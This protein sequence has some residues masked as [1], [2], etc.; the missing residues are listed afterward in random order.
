MGF[1]VFGLIVFLTL[2][3][4]ALQT[5]FNNNNNNNSSN[6]PHDPLP[7]SRRGCHVKSC[8]ARA[9]IHI[10]PLVHTIG[11]APRFSV[12]AAI[13]QFIPTASHPSPGDNHRS[14]G[15]RSE[16]TEPSKNGNLKLLHMHHFYSL[17]QPHQVSATRSS[18]VATPLL[19]ACCIHHSAGGRS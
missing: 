1:G 4:L 11:T 5:H 9:I 12:V 6:I 2:S 13:L 14:M 15:E 16:R 7:L 8:C 18:Q 19:Y 10:H 3:Q 17:P